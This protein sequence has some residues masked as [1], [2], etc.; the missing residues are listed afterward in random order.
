ML[1]SIQDPRNLG[2][3]LRCANAAGVDCVVVNKDGSA[4]INAVVHKTSAGAINQT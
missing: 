1:D 3:C 4:P 2:A